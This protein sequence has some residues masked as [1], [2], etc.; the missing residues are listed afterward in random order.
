MEGP[1]SLSAARGVLVGLLGSTRVE[2]SEGRDGGGGEVGGE[3]ADRDGGVDGEVEGLVCGRLE[4]RVDLLAGV[5]GG[6]EAADAVGR[7]DRGEIEVAAEG[8]DASP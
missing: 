6:E 5:R 3:E 8:G 7:V 2:E 1:A 4:V